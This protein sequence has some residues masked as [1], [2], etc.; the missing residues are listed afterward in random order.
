MRTKQYGFTL[1]ELMIVV[2]IVGIL[3]AIALPAYQRYVA[4]AQTAEGVVLLEGAKTAVD[5]YV[6]QTGD[7]PNSLADLEVLGVITSGKF[8]S[9]VEGSRS[10]FAAGDLLAQFHSTN[11]SKPIQGREM[12]FTRESTGR[13][14]CGAGPTAPIA[15]IY[16]PQAC[17]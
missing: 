12:R 17:R 15:D 6:S 5:E 9:T 16:L 2:A 13:W 1:I 10:G 3:A 8:V 14:S 4:R 11:V 7:F